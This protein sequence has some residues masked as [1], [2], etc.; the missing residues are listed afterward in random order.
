MGAAALAL[1]VREPGLRRRALAVE[2]G[3]LAALLASGLALLWLRGLSPFQAR[4][5]VLKLGLVAFL[6]LPLEAMHAF[7]QHWWLPEARRLAETGKGDR[8]LERAA[9]MAAMVRTLGAPLIGAAIPLLVWL[10]VRKPF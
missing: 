3:A 9:G 2:H 8:E 10:S 5:M 4:W 1:V 7:A 6:V